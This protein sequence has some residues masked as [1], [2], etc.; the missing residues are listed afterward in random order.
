MSEIF[1]RRPFPFDGNVFPQD[2]GAVVMKSVLDGRLP[3]LQVVHTPDNAWAIADGLHDP[4]EPG[5]CEVAHI[6]HVLAIDRSLIELSTLPIGYQADREA[7][8]VPWIISKFAWG[9][10]GKRS[11]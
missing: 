7:R 10:E 1:R 2:L 9:T 11:A 8:G 5:A 4:N 3:A 6:W